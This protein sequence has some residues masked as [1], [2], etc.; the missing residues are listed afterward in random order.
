VSEPAPASLV[1]GAQ[2]SVKSPGAPFLLAA[3]L[4]RLAFLIA[5]RTLET[6]RRST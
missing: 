1:I 4:L 5:V 6:T 3:A 2:A